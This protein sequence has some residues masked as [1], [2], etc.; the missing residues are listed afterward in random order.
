MHKDVKKALKA[1]TKRY[2]EWSGEAV[3]TTEAANQILLA[4]LRNLPNSTNSEHGV[5]LWYPTRIVVELT[6]EE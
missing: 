6:G 5:S 4:F 3:A 2:E 1:A